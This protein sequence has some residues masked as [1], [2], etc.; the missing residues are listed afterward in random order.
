MIKVKLTNADV[1]FLNNN[2][3]NSNKVKAY[4]VSK[5]LTDD[6]L[7]VSPSKK[8]ENLNFIERNISVYAVTYQASH[9]LYFHFVNKIKAENSGKIPLVYHKTAK[10]YFNLWKEQ[11]EGYWI[12]A[13]INT[14]SSNKILDEH[15]NVILTKFNGVNTDS[16]LGAI[17]I[18]LTILIALSLTVVVIA[19][20]NHLINAWNRERIHSK[21]CDT[22]TKLA[23]NYANGKISYQAYKASLDSIVTISKQASKDSWWKSL[24]IK[25]AAIG[26]LSVLGYVGYQHYV[27]KKDFKSIFPIGKLASNMG[28]GLTNS[29]AVKQIASN[30]AGAVAGKVIDKYVTGSKGV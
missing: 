25:V 15:G 21:A 13:L 4:F 20:S 24:A 5:G 9:D 30:S 23:S 26:G 29:P 18:A 7:G 14:Y 12:L 17:S 11:S 16:G 3:N 22:I 8:K 2:A 10:K 6:Q 28:K 1:N 27:L 19:V